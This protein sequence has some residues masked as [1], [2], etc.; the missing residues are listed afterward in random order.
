MVVRY[1]L[2]TNE[3]AQQQASGRARAEDSVYSVVATEGGREIRRE[4][5]NEYLEELTAKAINQVQSMNPKEFREKVCTLNLNSG[6]IVFNEK[7]TQN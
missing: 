2:L 4:L 7:F 1:G 5:T 3:I 6:Q